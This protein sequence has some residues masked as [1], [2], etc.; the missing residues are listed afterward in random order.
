MWTCPG[1]ASPFFPNGNR[2]LVGH[3]LVKQNKKCQV[4]Q[5]FQ[6]KLSCSSKSWVTDPGHDHANS[7]DKNKAHVPLQV[8]ARRIR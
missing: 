8:E 4:L 3:G 5:Q 2:N 6:K 7:A 1:H